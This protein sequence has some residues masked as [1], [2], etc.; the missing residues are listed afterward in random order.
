MKPA[1]PVT[2]LPAGW[3]AALAALH[4]PDGARVL[5]VPVPQAHLTA[6][7]RWQADGSRPFS[8]IGGYFIGAMSGG[9]VARFACQAAIGSDRCDSGSGLTGALVGGIAGGI[10]GVH[11]ANR[12]TEDLIYHAP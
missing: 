6:A 7:M 5:V 2:A 10:Y 8:L 3:S 12:Q 11:A 1:A 4:L 9:M